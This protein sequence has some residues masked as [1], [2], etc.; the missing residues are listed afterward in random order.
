V[1][2]QSTAEFQLNSRPQMNQQKLELKINPNSK[3]LFAGSNPN[4]STGS[5]DA[6]R[7]YIHP[8]LIHTNISL[9]P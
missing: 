1:L 3:E 4:T 2:P 9:T 5:A 8:L 6:G 7:N